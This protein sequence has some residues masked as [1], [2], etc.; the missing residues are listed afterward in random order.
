MPMEQRY[1]T[2]E[3]DHK[4]MEA[5]VKKQLSAALPR[6]QKMLL[7]LQKYTFTLAYKPGKEMLLADILSC[8]YL[9]DKPASDD[10][11]EDLN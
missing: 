3:S 5:I 4:P 7:Q 11:K 6:L 9:H 8:A 10:L 1:V 2:V